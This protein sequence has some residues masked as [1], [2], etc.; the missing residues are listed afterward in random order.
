[1]QHFA[2]T[3]WID[4]LNQVASSS[5]KL[6]MEKH[7]QEGCE[8][9]AKTLA[10]W[11]RIRQALVAEPSYQPPTE[12]V[13]IAKA[14]FA[15]SEW[16]LERKAA[17]RVTEVLFDSFMHLARE[18]VR[19]AGNGTRRLLYRADPFQVDLQIEAPAGSSKIL[20][21][22]QLLDLRHPEIDGRDVPF[23]LSNLRGQVIQATTNQ[24][25]EFREEIE[26]SG[27]LELVFHRT[28]E[29]PILVSLPD[30]LGPSTSQKS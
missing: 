24:F 5:E 17:S 19:S 16:A 1:M 2:N 12:A 14:A 8:R 10:R 29:K 18:G 27:H 9:C 6:A 4:L 28:T 22:G 20:V 21:V 15:G 26:N 11:Q 23:M 7:L 25:G 30:A 13:R 3:E